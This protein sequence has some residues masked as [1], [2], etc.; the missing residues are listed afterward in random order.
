MTTISLTNHRA[1]AVRQALSEA[2]LRGPTSYGADSPRGPTTLTWE[3]DLTTEEQAAVDALV[4][5]SVGAVIIT[6]A[7]LQAIR[8]DI[9]VIRDLRQLGRNP[10]MAL[11]AADRDRALY[12]AQSATTTILLAMLRE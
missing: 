6:P 12:D 10:F 7:E 1:D 2:G 11:T 8:D 9:V 3:P 5:L 4:R